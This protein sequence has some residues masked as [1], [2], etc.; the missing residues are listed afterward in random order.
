[1][2]TTTERVVS[3]QGSPEFY[4]E[5]E[6]LIDNGAS[7]TDVM[8]HFS[9]SEQSA[10]RHISFVKGRMRG[11]GAAQTTVTHDLPPPVVVGR[12][13]PVAVEPVQLQGG[14]LTR[15]GSTVRLGSILPPPEGGDWRLENV[16]PDQLRQMAPADLIGRMIRISPEMSRANFD[17]LRMANPGHDLKAVNPGTDVPNPQGQ[18]YLDYCEKQLD[19]RNGAADVVYNSHLNNAYIRGAVFSEL[20]LSPGDGRTFVDIVVPDAYSARFRLDPDPETG[21]NKWQLIQGT[22]RDIV[23]LD[24]PTVKYVAVDQFPDTPYGTSPIAPGLFPAL[25]LITMLQDARRVVAQQGWP[26]LDIMVEVAE[27]IA[28]MKPDDQKDPEKVRQ[29]VQRAVDQIAD[30]Y[31]NLDPDQAWV[32]SSTVKFGTP[33]GAIGNLQGV[34]ALVD[35]LERMCVRAM[36]SQPLLFG[37][38]E[39]VSEANA[40]RQWEVQV[41]GVQALQRLVESTLS[42]HFSLALE[43]VGI[44]ATAKFKFHELR[45]IEDLR[46]AQAFFQKLENSQRAELLGYWTHDEAAMYAVGHPAAATP[47]GVVGDEVPEGGTTNPANPEAGV[48]MEGD[49][50]DEDDIQGDSGDN[51]SLRIQRIDRLIDAVGTPESAHAVA[52]ALALWRARSLSP[53]EA[54]ATMEPEGSPQASGNEAVTVD[55]T[56]VAAARREFDY[57]VPDYAGIL[58][59]ETA[60]EDDGGE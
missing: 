7:R 27:I 4:A 29:T 18:E 51:R 48:V 44:A 53:A 39:G 1:V 60:A 25:F 31:A 36:K 56:D 49:S 8:R 45:A 5:L 21:S 43:A 24:R 42:S 13:V 32:H 37:L 17:F 10:R 26:R 47:I 28:T 35:V 12:Q 50:G 20:V 34:D 57:R 58:N 59:A 40:N 2:S 52:Y 54:R 3:E 11:S 22:G 9:I 55:G 41:E 16:T 46:D 6:R 38:P 15:L 33:I 19:R 14:R 30:S 23:V